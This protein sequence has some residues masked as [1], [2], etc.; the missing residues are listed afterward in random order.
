VD[1]TV[2]RVEHLRGTLA[3][4]GDKSV[5]HRG[6]ILA[7]MAGGRCSIRG[8]APGADV[9]STAE[10]LRRLGL[11]LALGPVPPLLEVDG[12]GWQVRPSASLDAGN[13]GTTMRLLAGA[14]AGRPGT[15]EISGDA[16]LSA[17]PMERVAVP[18]R[19]MG[20]GVTLGPGGRPPMRIDGGPLRGITYPM[21]VAS[22]QVKGAILLA[23]LQAAGVTRVTE[24]GPSRDHT[25][26]LFSWLGLPVLA[27]PGWVEL[28]A[29]EHLPLPAFALD[30]PGDF[31]SAAFW[32]T[33]AA[34]VAGSDIRLPGVG[35]NTSRTGLVDVLSAMGASVEVSPESVEPE[36][37]GA[38][39]VHSAASGGLQAIEVG[40]DLVA[41]T[42][43]E[44]PL[45]AVAATQAEGTT[46]IRDAAEL[47]VKESDRLAVLA[48]GLRA[49]GADIEEAPDGLV[50]H[51][52]SALHG[53]TVD[54][55]GDHRMAMAFAVA[56]MTASDPV[57]IGGWESTVISYPGFLDHLAE[58]SR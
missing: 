54:A 19:A 46:V 43:D 48:A 25:E 22:A 38:I 39:R 56:A 4:P 20:A 14:L 57:T 42:I 31:S 18:L 28:A 55:H 27:G 34:V 45:V 32:V 13:S 17:R 49:L 1:V 26:R 29:G 23:A 36:P 2:G 16:S 40:G 44:L 30:V 35:V 41:R 12:I 8:A 51:G 6:L 37:V 58:L 9:A 47:R 52:P 5:S 53:G 3:V 33:A 11:P 50:I 24:P 15:Y 21:P 7:A 10:C